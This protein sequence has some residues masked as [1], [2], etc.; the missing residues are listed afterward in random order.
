MKPSVSISPSLLKLYDALHLQGVNAQ[1]FSSKHDLLNKQPGIDELVSLDT[2]FVP[3]EGLFH[4]AT[5]KVELSRGCKSA[6][7]ESIL[8][9]SCDEIRKI[10]A[11]RH[12]AVKGGTESI[13]AQ[14]NVILLTDLSLENGDKAPGS[15]SVRRLHLNSDGLGTLSVDFLIDTMHSAIHGDKASVVAEVDYDYF[16]KVVFPFIFTVLKPFQREDVY[17]FQL[18]PGFRIDVA[19]ELPDKSR[20]AFSHACFNWEEPELGELSGMSP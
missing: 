16:S 7:C 11:E 9:I 5:L 1:L 6:L 10:N 14:S 4:Q 2:V 19:Q 18:D 3:G 13:E 8:F 12:A 15:V 20:A 17:A